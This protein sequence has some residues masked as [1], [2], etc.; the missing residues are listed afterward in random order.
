MKLKAVVLAGGAEYYFDIPCGNGERSIKWLASACSQ[1]Y[2]TDFPSQLNVRSIQCKGRVLDPRSAIS[3]VLK[4]KDEVEVLLEDEV[5]LDEAGA[6]ILSAWA[7]LAY[8]RV[9]HNDEKAEEKGDG[10][11]LNKIPSI[12]EV[13]EPRA[14]RQAK[15]DFIHTTMKQQMLNWSKISHQVKSL[16]GEIEPLFPNLSSSSVEDLK[17]VCEKNLL[18]LEEMFGRFASQSHMSLSEFQLLIEEAKV[19]S[20]KE[21]SSLSSRAFLFI[22][23]ASKGEEDARMGLT[24]STFIAALLLVSQIRHNDT[25]QSSHQTILMPVEDFSLIIAENIR[26]LAE[27]QRYESLVREALSSDDFLYR[28]FFLR[29]DLFTIFD[30][31]ERAVRIEYNNKMKLIINGW[32]SIGYFFAS[33]FADARASDGSKARRR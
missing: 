23:K 1:R 16:W 26:P 19:F 5:S 20:T 25:F 3:A 12:E 24:L 15:I 31:A 33:S 13:I 14:S 29:K 21:S 18:I 22:S 27:R 32:I 28:L 8:G 30:K 17:E 11:L 9:S 2:A 7:R 10:F 4:E 6:P